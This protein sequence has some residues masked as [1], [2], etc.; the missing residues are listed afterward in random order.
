LDFWVLNDTLERSKTA[1]STAALS[2]ANAINTQQSNLLNVLFTTFTQADSVLSS[3]RSLEISERNFEYATER[4]R[5]GQSSVKD[6]GDASSQIITSR[7]S[8]TR[9][10]YGFLQSLSSL[11][12]LLAIDDEARLIALLMSR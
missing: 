12:S 5:L 1:V 7:N 6:F 10:Y 8:Y 4:Y 2:Y 9:A 3:R 11:R